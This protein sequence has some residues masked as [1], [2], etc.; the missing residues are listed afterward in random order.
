MCL[1]HILTCIGILL[2]QYHTQ[3]QKHSSYLKRLMVYFIYFIGLNKRELFDDAWST[4]CRTAGLADVREFGPVM[5]MICRPSF[6]D[7][8]G[9]CCMTTQQRS[10]DRWLRDLW[11]S[12]RGL[13]NSTKVWLFRSLVVTVRDR[14]KLWNRRGDSHALTIQW[15]RIGDPLDVHTHYTTLPSGNVYEYTTIIPSTLTPSPSIDNS[16]DTYESGS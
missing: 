3:F 6:R 7:S 9:L 10:F 4:M 16:P 11:Y 13:L 15:V 8:R 5:N 12:Y 1:I 2:L 14:F